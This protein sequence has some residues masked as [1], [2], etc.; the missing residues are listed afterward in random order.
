MPRCFLKSVRPIEGSFIHKTSEFTFENELKL[1]APR[2]PNKGLKINAQKQ[3]LKNNETIYHDKVPISTRFYLQLLK[4]SQFLKQFTDTETYEYASENEKPVTLTETSKN[5]TLLNKKY[6]LRSSEATTVRKSYRTFRTQIKRRNETQPARIEPK[7]VEIKPR[8]VEDKDIK[9]PLVPAAPLAPIIEEIRKREPLKKGREIDKI[10]EKLKSLV[11]LD[12][13]LLFCKESFEEEN[14][15][16]VEVEVE[17]EVSANPKVAAVRSRAVHRCEHC[18][19]GFDRPWVL[20]GHMRLHTGERPFPCPQP[21]CGRSFADRGTCVCTLERDPSRARSRSVAGASLTGESHIHCGKGFDRPWVL[22]G[23][24]RL[25]TGER[26]FPCPQPQCGRSFADRSNLR[27]HQRTRGHH[28]WQWR[29]ERCGKP[30][31]DRRYLER[32]GAPACRNYKSNLRAHPR[33]R[34]HHAWQWRCER[35]GKPFSDRRYLE[36]HGAPA[37]R[38]YKYVL[39]RSNLRAHPRTRGH[40]AWQWRCERCGQPFSDRRYLERHGAPACRNYK[41]NLTENNMCQN[42][43]K[44]TNLNLVQSMNCE[45]DMPMDLSIANREMFA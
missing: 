44:P 7:N 37:C 32:H 4:R 22:K 43:N 20:K 19:K 35:C 38:N 10:A 25:H 27:A 16:P 5:K 23:H 18:G 15:E 11:K 8:I 6:N 17:T 42:K 24:M 31:S 36:R 39:C 29:C 2:G 28:A 21:Q 3:L 26:P 34:G 33:T 12:N 41:Y 13:E 9:E 30:F 40:H 1:V 45:Q 14:I